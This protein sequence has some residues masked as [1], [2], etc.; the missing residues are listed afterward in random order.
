EGESLEHLVIRSDDGVSAATYA[1]LPAVIEALE[2]AGAAHAYAEDSQRHLAP[3]KGSELMAEQDGRFELAFGGT[4]T[5]AT[6]AL[7]TAL[8][9]AGTF[10]D[11]TIVDSTT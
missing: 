1:T 2:H 7:R 3:P 9:E 4:A 8:R 5:Q 11:T 6:A 10:L